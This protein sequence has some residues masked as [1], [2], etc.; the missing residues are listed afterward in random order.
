MANIINGIVIVT[1]VLLVIIIFLYLFKTIRA[2]IKA[3]NLLKQGQ[4][5]ENFVYDLLRTNYSAAKIIRNAYY[6]FNNGRTTEIDLILVARGGIHV[7]EVK[8]MRG[9]ID[10]PFKGDW[11]QTYN[12]KM[13]MF[14]NP[15]EQN[16][17]HIKAIQQILKKE[18]IS[19]AP[20]H[21]IV[22]FT[23]PRV[24]FKHKEEMLLT[25]NNFLP[26]LADI[27]RNK[28]LKSH[29]IR[30]ISN[31]LRKYKLKGRRVKREHIDSIKK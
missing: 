26:F 10:N 22:V 25:C 13:F 1:V 7:I 3:K 29:D 27:N 28:F 2:E 30:Y 16:V 23:D 11:C 21:N 20:I 5:G 12:N 14:Q 9:Y 15:F 31:I 6:R 18:E 8:S 24:K 17:G 4:K 19:N